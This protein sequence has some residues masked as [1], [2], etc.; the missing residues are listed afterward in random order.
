MI[1]KNIVICNFKHAKICGIIYN[2]IYND[3]NK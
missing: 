2:K 1:E 3:I